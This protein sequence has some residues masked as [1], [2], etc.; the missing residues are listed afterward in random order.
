MLYR[1]I[2]TAE[3]E[4]RAATYVDDDIDLEAEAASYATSGLF[5]APITEGEFAS[6]Q[7]AVAD[8]SYYIDYIGVE[9][10]P[11]LVQSPPK[12]GEY[13]DFNFAT[14][15]WVV[16]AERL[17]QAKQNKLAQL[18]A[19]FMARRHVPILF[20]GN[21]YSP[22]DEM[23]R[24]VRS[25]L[26]SLEHFGFNPA[27]WNGIRSP[28]GGR[29]PLHYT[30]EED[31]SYLR[32]MLATMEQQRARCLAVLYAHQDGIGAATTVEAVLAYDFSYWWPT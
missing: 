9:E 7:A 31:V 8:D 21:P 18:N 29:T 16:S 25:F 1:A 17:A 3:G 2:H 27:M 13:Y 6:A 30:L 26:E 22:T 28:N 5:V 23:V 32:G 19:E 15:T 14:H 10:A 24:E 12:P 20:N 11:T 4:I